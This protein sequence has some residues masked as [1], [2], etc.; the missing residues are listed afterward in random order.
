M[1]RRILFQLLSCYCLFLGIIPNAHAEIEKVVVSWDSG[2]CKEWCH[3]TLRKTFEEMPEVAQVITDTSQSSA[4]LRWKPN[5]PFDFRKVDYT[6]RRQGL[7]MRTTPPFIQLRGTIT[8]AD[9]EVYITSIGDGTR[10]QLLSPPDPATTG[11]VN[12]WNIATF[13]LR[14]EQRKILLDAES[15]QYVVTIEGHL[16]RPQFPPLRL[17]AEEIRVH[18]LGGE[19]VYKFTGSGNW[20]KEKTPHDTQ[21]SE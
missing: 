12:L 7:S 18:R 15:K 13:R 3:N 5:Q 16:F 19:K 11:Y 9:K 20:R 8:H 14:K 4:T 1:L 17:I 10:F 21:I 2:S 6:L